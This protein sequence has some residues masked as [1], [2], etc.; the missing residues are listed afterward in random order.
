MARFEA[1][2][3]EAGKYR[4]TNYMVVQNGEIAGRYN[5]LS[6]HRVNIYSAGKSFTSTAVGIAVKEGLLAL[7]EKVCDCFKEECAPILEKGES[8]YLDSLW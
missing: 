7:N 8:P 2:E 5:Y 3:K 6:E 1:F 4:V